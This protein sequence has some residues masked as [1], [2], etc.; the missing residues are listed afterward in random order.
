MDL[1]KYVKYFILGGSVTLFVNYLSEKFK[2]GPAL[3]AYLY[4]APDIYLVIMYV[5]YK[6]RGLKGYYTFIVHSLINYIANLLVILILVVL[7]NY[8]GLSIY[9]NFLLVSVL[10]IIYSIYYFL[11]VYKLEFTPHQGR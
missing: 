10:F 6:S 2:H 7:I 8:T 9:Q 3:T 11:Y 4:C 1:Y 5:I